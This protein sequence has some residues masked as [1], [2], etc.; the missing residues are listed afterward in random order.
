MNPDE[1]ETSTSVRAREC[2]SLQVFDESLISTGAV[3]KGLLQQMMQ[4]TAL[5]LK[6]PVV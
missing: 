4:F 3:I 1:K 6:S 2:P 5:K